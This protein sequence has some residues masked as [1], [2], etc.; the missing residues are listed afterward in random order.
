MKGGETVNMELDRQP[1]APSSIVSGLQLKAAR[2]MAGLTQAQLSTEAGFSP[3]AARYW[4]SRS[5]KPPT[6]VPSTLEAIEAVLRRY[7][8]ELFVSPTPGC[9]F[10]STK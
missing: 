3:R 6:N 10:I 8:V 7:G 2:V 4:E 9:R 1:L 5:D